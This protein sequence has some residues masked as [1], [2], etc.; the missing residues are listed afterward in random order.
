[1]SQ[2]D[3][4]KTHPIFFEISICRSRARP[5]SG[6]FI[7]I[8]M[9]FPEI[10]LVHDREIENSKKLDEFSINRSGSSNF[11]FPGRS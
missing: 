3:F 6:K 9:S 7:K 4:R 10:G 8:W 2:T 1:M 11:S 5:I